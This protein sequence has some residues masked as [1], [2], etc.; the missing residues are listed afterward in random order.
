M[1]KKQELKKENQIEKLTKEIN[2]L[3]NQLARAIAD[4]R[5]LEARIEKEA[6]LLRNNLSFSLIDKLLPVLD[7]LERAESH[8]KNQG[9]SLAV[10]QFKKVLES[11]GIKEIKA[12]G[13]RFDPAKMDCVEIVKGPKDIVVETVLKGYTMDGEVIRPVK[14]KVGKGK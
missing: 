6:T 8:L 11:E 9:L 12:E 5:N 10:S 7:D 14:V 13:E 4:Y 2:S 3:K 1:K